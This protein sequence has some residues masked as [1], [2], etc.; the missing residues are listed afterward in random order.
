[1][2]VSKVERR[3]H[4]R[5]ACE[6]K[7]LILHETVVGTVIDLSLGGL[8]CSCC[9]SDSDDGSARC[10]KNVDLFCINTK[11]WVRGLT[12]DIIV[13]EENPGQFLENFWIRKCRARFDN[14]RDEQ[15]GLLENLFN[16]CTNQ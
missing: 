4:Q 7:C 11:T 6:N 13:S 5:F 12:M 1:M 14:L 3:K 10:S 15:A 8:S 9:S 16:T 2:D